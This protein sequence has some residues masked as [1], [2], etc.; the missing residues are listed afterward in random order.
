MADRFP[1]IVNAVSKK[2]EEL[3]AGDNLDLTGNG[4]VV[5]GDTGA[6][7][8]LTSNGTTVSWGNP[9]DVYLTASQTLTNKTFQSCTLSGTNNL[10]SNIGNS[11]LVNSSIS[12]NGS[13][14]PL[15]GSVITPDNNTTYQIS[16]VDGVT[17]SQ[18]IIRL[19][20]GG[21]FN[22]GVNDDLTLEVTNPTGIPVGNNPLNLFLTRSSDVIR[23]SGYV[24]D[25]NTETFIVAQ[26]GSAQS[27][28]VT[29]QGTG[30]NVTLNDATKTVDIEVIDQ[31]TITNLHVT[32]GNLVNG[33][34]TLLATSPVQ[35]VQGQDVNGDPTFT[36][37][38]TDTIT[39]VKG[40]SAGQFKN[41]DLTI[42]G[43][44]TYG[45]T[46][47]S[48]SP[49]GLTI[50]VDSPN[51]NTITK[52]AANTGTLVAGDF[53]FTSSG[54]TTITA[55]TV[56][57][58]TTFDFNSINTDTGAILTASNGLIQSSNDFQ[59]KN[60]G[61]LTDTNVLKWDGVN[62]Q[63]TSSIIQDDGSTITIGGNLIVTGTNTVLNTT[64]LTVKDP[65]IELRTGT[66]LVDGS[67][68]IQVNRTTD[69]SGTPITY[70][71]LQ[72]FHSGN[73]W[74][75]WDG[76]IGKPIVTTTDTQVLTNKTLSSP[77]FTGTP[78]LG[79]ATATTINGLIISATTGG[80]LTIANTK[81]LT[82]S[83]SVTLKGTDGA[84][85][86]FGNGPSAGYRV[87]YTGDTLGAFA[88]TTSSQLQGIMTDATGVGGKLMFSASPVITTSLQSSSGTFALLNAGPTTI[89]AFGAATTIN[90]GKSGGST[91]IL[92]NIDVETNAVFG[93]N[94]GDVFRV[95]GTANFDA[96]DIYIRGTDT[97]PIRIGRGEN[98]IF[99]NTGMGYR[100]FQSN[101][102]GA[103]NI[104]FGFESLLTN[105]GGDDNVGVGYRALKTNSTGDGNTA[106]GMNALLA[107]NGDGNTALGSQALY[108]IASGSH[109]LCLGYFAGYNITGSGNVLIGPATT[110]DDQSVT[111]QAISP[112]GNKQLVIGSGDTAWI[113]GTSNGDVTLPYSFRVNGDA[114]IDGDLIVSGSTVSINS[115]VLT[116]DDK[117]IELAAVS[118]V[119]IVGDITTGT[120]ITNV[121]STAGLVVGMEIT[122]SGTG[123][124]T[125]NAGTYITQISGGTVTVNQPINT[126]GNQNYTQATF[127]ADGP[128]ELAAEGG[129]LIVKGDTDHSILYSGQGVDKY[130]VFTE[131]LKLPTGKKI[132]TGAGNV[133]LISE[134]EL[135]A[136]ITSAPG[137]DTV[138]TLQ[139]LSVA[140]NLTVGGRVTE[141]VSGSFATNIT[142]ANNTYTISLSGTNTVV[143]TSPA[144]PINTWDFTNVNLDN[145]Q[146]VTVTLILAANTAATYG[147]ACNVDTISVAN[148]VQWSGG[149]PPLASS[150]TDILTFVIVKDGAGV[151][152][153]FGQGNTDF[154]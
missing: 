108:T 97:Y 48:Q 135:G 83:N 26:G 78:V 49:D 42:T 146:S 27:G 141:D 121:V 74:R 2:I 66:N 103:R 88:P 98:S 120:T 119:V 46:V 68:G 69:S 95:N 118:S 73:Y 90:V 60:A 11:S 7:K 140:G 101:T 109:N 67:G 89:N 64:T 142:V 80:T 6:G 96:S 85:V 28:T 93:T 107:S 41:G 5:S 111:Y 35:I 54:A 129:G 9:G 81:T 124:V 134:T 56:A 58:V 14:V 92:G 61:N 136:S 86:D 59:I 37:S 34:I 22:P 147:D 12:I 128:T 152:R 38:S 50:F 82:V 127:V 99:N 149:S 4:L 33:D 21:N 105:T 110:G 57:G 150:N 15:G 45:N 13:P 84:S 30:C 3:V 115:T 32:G 123:G 44:S 153:V 29:F 77:T 40:G 113:R 94:I 154:S 144:T 16:A 114:T 51:D 52:L 39:R 18:K 62:G 137:L 131:N 104:A 116:V 43:G 47:V 148:G 31:D 145:G 87:A 143:G 151:T 71:A 79:T 19:T 70:S 36:W 72:F 65:T 132:V 1:L 133:L 25:N 125:V 91:N 17:A 100:I 10:I 112:S 75:V 117:N 24:L 138:G 106:V 102:T 76:S 139:S 8:Y 122:T 53:R 126:L 55:S 130:W 20:S 23:L 63:L